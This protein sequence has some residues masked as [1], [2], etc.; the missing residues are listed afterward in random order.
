MT[1]VHRELRSIIVEPSGSTAS[2]HSAALRVGPS[3]DLEE[4]RD[5]P[6]FVAQLDR[7]GQY[8]VDDAGG[9]QRDS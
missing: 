2:L 6:P 5:I 9:G 4:R 3:E 8:V 7:L 1:T